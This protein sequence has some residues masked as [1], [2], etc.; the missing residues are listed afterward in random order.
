MPTSNYMP[1][2]QVEEL[3]HMVARPCDNCGTSITRKAAHF[4]RHAYCS[5]KCYRGSRER[6][7]ATRRMVLGRSPHGRQIVTCDHCGIEFS[8]QTNQVRPRNFCNP[9]CYHASKVAR[10]RKPNACGYISIYVGKDVAGA[11]KAGQMLEHR[12]VAQ[13]AL[14]RPLRPEENVHHKN[15]IRTD[16]RIENLELWTTSQPPG[17]R[18]SDKIAWAKEFLALY[19][20]Q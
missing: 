12:W 5:Q 9:N 4:G 11:T 8:R 17:Q 3:S 6:A 13:E 19:G 15:G 20:E 14:G 18:V 7:E 16:N 2:V 10:G 1:D